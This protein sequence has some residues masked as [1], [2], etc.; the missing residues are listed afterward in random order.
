MKK[1]FTIA[2]IIFSLSLCACNTTNTLPIDS[3]ATY[4]S[5][6]G[7]TVPAPQTEPV[8]IE[9]IKGAKIT[10]EPYSTGG[11]KDYTVLGK[12]YVVWR[13]VKSYQEIGIASWYGPGFHGRNTSNGERY[14]MNGYTAAHKNL[15][16]PSFLK[17]TNL[18]NGKAIIV[19]VNDRGP[20]HQNRI[21]DL[22]K[23]AASALGVIGPGTAKVKIVLIKVKSSKKQTTEDVMN[24]FKPYIQV[25]TTDDYE[26]ALDIKNK[27]SKLT[28]QKT[29]LEKSNNKYRIKV[30]PLTSK[31]STSTMSIIK[32]SGYNNAFFSSK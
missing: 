28:K 3:D 12:K 2:L 27:I 22:S 14:N 29:F 7:K 13:D 31:N 25:F 24:G 16:L 10:D 1:L 19:R 17:V 20:F 30:G 8:D 23:G 5:G 18:S 26:K 32:R 4:G 21:L 9:G 6:P 15:P 11:N